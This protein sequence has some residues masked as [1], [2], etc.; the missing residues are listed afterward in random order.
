MD[1]ISTDQTYRV[2]YRGGTPESAHRV[3]RIV[4]TVTAVTDAYLDVDTGEGEYTVQ[5]SHVRSV[6]PTD[7]A[8][9]NHRRDL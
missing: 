9:H 2:E 4:G 8:P 6:T 1:E 5:R 7:A 3:Y